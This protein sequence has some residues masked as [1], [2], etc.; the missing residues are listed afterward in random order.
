MNFMGVVTAYNKQVKVRGA[1]GYTGTEFPI[2][3]GKIG[4]KF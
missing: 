4:T 3:K 2:V 1:S